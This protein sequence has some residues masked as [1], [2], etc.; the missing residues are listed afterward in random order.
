[1][2]SKSFLQISCVS[3]IE[4]PIFH[5]QKNVCEVHYLIGPAI[6]DGIDT[7]ALLICEVKPYLSSF[8]KPLVVL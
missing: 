5:A 3:D 1:M 4:F 6:F 8:G 2:L 7:A